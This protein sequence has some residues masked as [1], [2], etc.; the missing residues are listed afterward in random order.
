[1]K[2]RPPIFQVVAAFTLFTAVVV[3][4]GVAVFGPDDPLE[5]QLTAPDTAAVG[6]KVVLDVGDTDA[7]AYGYAVF[8]QS[9]CLIFEEGTKL[10]FS[11]IRPGPYQF[12]ITA[13]KGGQLGL[14]HKTI[15]VEGE[16]PAPPG[17]P[18]FEQQLAKLVEKVQSP[19]KKTE[20]L[21]LANT[22]TTV[23]SM[24]AAGRFQSVQDIHD[25]TRRLNEEAL[26][27]NGAA[28]AP[29]RTGLSEILR[30]RQDL[31]TVEEFA[32][33]WQAIGRALRSIGEAL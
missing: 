25:E 30:A 3:S 17:P 29:L 4:G 24:A 10:V 20:C 18:S 15:V 27:A 21:L 8:P 9:E 5:I 14:L 31:S 19:N 2:P 11:D 7:D 16:P 23:G 6:E 13:A 1:M 26:G 33:T 32:Q 12:V 22:F 28:W